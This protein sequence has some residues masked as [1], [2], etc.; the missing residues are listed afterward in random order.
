MGV[1]S[2]TSLI[3]SNTTPYRLVRGFVMQE[4]RKHA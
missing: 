4:R 2:K 1:T 3:N